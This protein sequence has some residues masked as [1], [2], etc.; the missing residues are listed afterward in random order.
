MPLATPRSPARANENITGQVHW[1]QIV[2]DQRGVRWRLGSYTRRESEARH[3]GTHLSHN[4]PNIGFPP[5]RVHHGD[6]AA[7]CGPWVYDRCVAIYPIVETI[8]TDVSTGH[9]GDHHSY[10]D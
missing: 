2:L 9:G 7:K 5:D 3:R 10:Y 6:N 1:R 4:R 8:H